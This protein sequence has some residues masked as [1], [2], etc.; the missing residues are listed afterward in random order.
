MTGMSLIVKQV[1][2]LIT[3]FIFVY[4]IYLILYG[5]LSPGGGFVGGVTLGCCFILMVLAFGKKFTNTMIS[6][7]ATTIFDCVG[8]MGFLLIALFGYFAGAFFLNF[9][10]KTEGQEFKLISAGTIPLGNIFIGLKVGACLAGVFAALI[11][12]IGRDELAAGGKE[13]S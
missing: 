10:P 4:S 13:L 11:V 1:S 9:I 8:A 12:F 3:G 2:K 7:R 6:D 5:H